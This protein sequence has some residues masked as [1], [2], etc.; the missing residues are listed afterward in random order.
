MFLAT[1]RCRPQPRAADA[2]LR[3]NL[4]LASKIPQRALASKLKVGGQAPQELDW[5]ASWLPAGAPQVSPCACAWAPAK[6][7]KGRAVAGASAVAAASRTPRRRAHSHPRALPAR[8]QRPARSVPVLNSGTLR[9]LKTTTSPLK[10]VTPRRRQKQ[11]C[12][13]LSPNVGR[14]TKAKGLAGNP[15]VRWP[16]PPEVPF[17]LS[18][19]IH[20]SIKTTPLSK[21]WPRKPLQHLSGYR[22]LSE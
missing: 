18:F 11:P 3:P 4:Q 19:G 16:G 10:F 13:P 12:H 14:A 2:P 5:P 7:T 8:R 15:C 20:S 1:P 6:A 9:K 22:A 17:R 21:L